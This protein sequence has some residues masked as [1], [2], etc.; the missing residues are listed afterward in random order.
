MKIIKNEFGGV[1]TRKVVLDAVLINGI[2]KDANPRLLQNEKETPYH[3]V[4][5]EL[6]NLENGTS[7]VGSVIVWHTNFMD[8]PNKYAEGKSIKVE[9]ALEG[10]G[11]GVAQEHITNGRF[12][13]ASLGLSLNAL[14]EQVVE[15][16]MVI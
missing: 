5:V 4:N 11:M 1:I 10:D 12:D 6:Q 2:E 3:W 8:S 15:Q 14:K 9:I 16:E 7:Q 13:L